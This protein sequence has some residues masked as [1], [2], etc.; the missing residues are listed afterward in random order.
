[1]NPDNSS[2]LQKMF[3]PNNE[4][5]RTTRFFMITSNFISIVKNKEEETNNFAEKCHK[6]LV[7]DQC[8]QNLKKEEVAKMD[9]NNIESCLKEINYLASCFMFLFIF[10]SLFSLWFMIIN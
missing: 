9:K 4:F 1:M 3:I 6:C 2:V 8:E 10:F 5:E 7:C